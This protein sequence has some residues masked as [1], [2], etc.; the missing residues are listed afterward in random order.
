[1]SILYC[2]TLTKYLAGSG[3]IIGATTVTLTDLTDIYGNVLTMANFGS[4]G[5]ITLEPKTTNE[6]AATFTG[7]TA[8]ANGTYTLTGVKTGIAVSP[9]TETSGLVRQHAGGTQ[10]VITDTVQF[11]NTF[12]NKENNNAFTG[13]NTVP[14]P[15][16]VTEIAN[17]QWVLS[18]VNGGAVSFDQLIVPGTA[19]ET[20]SQGDLVYF[21]VADGKWWKTDADTSATLFGVQLGFAQS[22]GTADVV[23]TGG[24][25]VRGLDTNHSGTAG[26]LVYASNTPG[27][28]SSSAG[29]TSKVIGQYAISSAGIYFNPEFYEIIT[30]AQAAA[31]AGASTVPTK[32]VFNSSVTSKGA[33]DSQ[34]DITNPAGTTFRY[35]WDTT[36]T[37]PNITAATMPI[38]MPILIFNNTMNAHNRGAFIVT[39]S[40]TNYFEIDN[41]A[42]V[43]ENNKT[44]S[45]GYL[46]VANIQ[47][48]TRPAGLK[49]ATFEVQGSGGGG[50]NGADTSGPS[51][52][53]DASGAAGGYARKIMTSA[54]IGATKNI[55]VGI[56]GVN[57]NDPLGG[58]ASAVATD[59]IATGASKYAGTGSAI[60]GGIG[61]GG[62][63]N[64]TGGD[65]YSGGNSGSCGG[66]GG[67]SFFGGGGY[68]AVNGA[69]GANDGQAYGAG[70]GGGESHGG[71]G[72]AGGVG[73]NG[74]IIVTE[75]Y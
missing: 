48:Y 63:I 61:I 1:M 47:T 40:G 70:G 9:Y 2:Q 59:I 52:H 27:A 26:G 34:F 16:G 37:D 7:V 11:W 22:A 6:E 69:H 74:I 14:D 4:K 19:G 57:G 60:Q 36:G 49:Y 35:T 32:Q 55:Y 54:D 29:T 42:G 15:V 51:S 50:Q 71:G 41:S 25:L 38:G 33:T 46:K 24:V 44:L 21:K 28:V 31:I 12:A 13:V 5:F 73:A 45:G 75:Y 39:G 56:G 18:V 66:T 65:G 67:A 23:I 43:A 30:P 72:S 3:V 17:K 8:N 64:V 20:L 68:G 53:G 10:V 62:D 58:M